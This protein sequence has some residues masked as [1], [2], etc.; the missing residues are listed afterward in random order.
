[1][2]H[3]ENHPCLFCPL[4]N[5]NCSNIPCDKLKMFYELQQRS[6]KNEID[7]QEKR[8]NDGQGTS[9]FR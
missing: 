6:K 7:E 8:G 1:M 9:F 3:S 5:D 2:K 4:K